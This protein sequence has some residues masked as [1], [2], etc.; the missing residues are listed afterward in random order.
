MA[1]PV[2]KFMRLRLHRKARRFGEDEQPDILDQAPTPPPAY[3]PYLRFKPRRA[4]KPPLKKKED[5]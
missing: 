2:D 5:T 1:L 4:N 3:R